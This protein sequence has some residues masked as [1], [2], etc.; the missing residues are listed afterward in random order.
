M[1][2][3][4]DFI[5]SLVTFWKD[6]LCQTI[7]DC[8]DKNLALELAKQLNLNED[9]TKEWLK[10]CTNKSCNPAPQIQDYEQLE[11]LY[12]NIDLSYEEE[13]KEMKK[14][15][16]KLKKEEEVKYE[17]LITNVIE[18]LLR[19]YGVSEKALERLAKLIDGI[20]TSIDVLKLGDETRISIKLK[21]T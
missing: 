9:Q 20:A 21:N 15:V 19:K 14:E 2:E 1:R 13:L 5:S 17:G 3:K 11:S 8:G 4:N 10:K 6:D 7:A 18:E 12:R 16:E